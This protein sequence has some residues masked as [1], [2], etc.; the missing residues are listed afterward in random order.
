M[1]F[2]KI[3]A[4]GK[5]SF[6]MSLPKSWVVKNNLKKGNLIGIE[7]NKG[8]L[9]LTPDANSEKLLEKDELDVTKLGKMTL[10]YMLALYKKGVDEIRVTFAKPELLEQI[11]NAIGKEAVGYEI[12]DQ[13]SNYCIIKNVAGELTEFDPVMRRT[14]LLL[15]SMADESLA[16]I[17]K[18]QFDQ[19]KSISFLE[20]G[21]NRFTTT[22]RRALNKGTYKEAAKV[23]PLYYIVEDIE[24]IADQYKYMCN[25]LYERRGKKIKLRKE[26]LDLYQKTNDM[27]REFYEMYYKYDPGKATD[28]GNKRKEI[29]AEF[30]N[31]VDSKPNPE[32]IVVLYNLMTIM[33]KIFCLVGP[34]LTM[35]I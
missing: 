15:I 33:Q 24:N 13:G 18:A 2:R 23:G 7:E 14:F 1:E 10:R 6:V 29:V 5:T 12:T 3:I 20:E 27:L 25:Y 16:N 30:F 31:I 22:L 17:K 26:I 19:L 9:V 8:T 32:E 28:I 21:N 11:Q 35:T 34:Y 4:F